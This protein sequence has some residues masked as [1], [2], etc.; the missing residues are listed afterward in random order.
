MYDLH[1]YNNAGLLKPSFAIY[2]AMVFGV[3]NLLLIFIPF[4]GSLKGGGGLDYLYDYVNLKFLWLDAITL[5]LWIALLTR[6][7]NQI[8]MFRVIWLNGRGLLL[9]VI[10]IGIIESIMSN[11]IFQKSYQHNFDLKVFYLIFIQSI[12]VLNLITSK[13]VKDLFMDWDKAK[14]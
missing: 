9:F 1:C 2:L 8:K 7:H 6:S 13:Y 14:H 3:K 5:L 11:F 12:L 10:S 4:F